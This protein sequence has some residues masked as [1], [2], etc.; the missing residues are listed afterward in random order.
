MYKTQLRERRQK[1]TES[2]PELGQ[3]VRRLTN[4]AYPMAPTDVRE[5][6]AK[7]QFVDGLTIADMRLCVKQAKPLNLSDAVRHAVELETFNKTERKRDDGRGYLR[8]TSQTNE[9]QECDTQTLTL[10]KSTHTM[11]SELQQEVKSLKDERRYKTSAYK[12][13]DLSK[14]KC[15]SCGSLGHIAKYCKKG[16][17]RGIK[18]QIRTTQTNKTRDNEEQ[19]SGSIGVSKLANEAGMFIMANVNGLNANM[20]VDTGATVTLVF[21]KLFESMTSPIMT[22]MKREILTASGSKIN[23]FGKT[24]I[25]IDING[26][27]CSNVAIVADINVDGILGLD[28]QRSQNCTINVAKGSILIHGHK[29]SLQ[30]EG[31]IGCYQVAMAKAVR[32][33]SRREVIVKRKAKDV[34]FL[35][36][37]EC[38]VY[39]KQFKEEKCRNS[40]MQCNKN[41]K[42]SADLRRHMQN[43]H[44]YKITGLDQVVESSTQERNEDIFSRMSTNH[45]KMLAPIK[46]KIIEDLKEIV[47]DVNSKEYAMYLEDNISN[48]EYLHGCRDIYCGHYDKHY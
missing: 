15:F 45:V 5:I 36:N 18:G 44:A 10:I 23:I 7:E 40:C 2:L 33:P 43:I 22:E 46:R 26:Y 11:L 6:L 12:Q 4:L 8:S 24:I 35:A 34:G 9:I 27:V 47:S 25:D 14:T 20:L 32:M 41:F 16:N 13:K 29:V 19:R 38:S 17:V 48:G 21:V 42:K 37:E 39:K 31:Q 3:D 28:F 30:F 1:A